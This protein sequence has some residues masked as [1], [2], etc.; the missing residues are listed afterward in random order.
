MTPV[1][2]PSCRDGISKPSALESVTKLLISS[3]LGDGSCALPCRTQV[4][5]FRS[6]A[7]VRL[8]GQDNP[9]AGASQHPRHAFQVVGHG[10][11]A[12]FRLRSAARRK[13]GCPKMRYFNSANSRSGRRRRSRMASAV[14]RCC[15]R[16]SA[17][18]SMCR[19]TT[20]RAAV[21]Q[22]TRSG[23][24]PHTAASPTQTTCRRLVQRHRKHRHLFPPLPL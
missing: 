18:S 21:L 2:G 1:L 22:R 14:P 4:G 3:G 7:Q 23:H 24:A 20:R 6:I 13:R 19:F 5:S 11:Q 9:Q 17:F 12:D 10:R 8:A 15:M 16:S